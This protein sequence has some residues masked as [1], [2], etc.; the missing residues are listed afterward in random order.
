M[1]RGQ[2]FTSIVICSLLEPDLLPF[3]SGWPPSAPTASPSGLPQMPRQKLAPQAGMLGRR[4]REPERVWVEEC[5][6]IQ[7]EVPAGARVTL[8]K[9]EVLV[10]DARMELMFL[11][12]QFTLLHRKD[13]SSTSVYRK[14][15]GSSLHRFRARGSAR[16]GAPARAPWRPREPRPAPPPS[17]CSANYTKAW[18]PAVPVP[19]HWRDLVF[20]TVRTARH[21]AFVSDSHL[22]R[23][24]LI[25]T[26]EK[27]FVQL[28]SPP[29]ERRLCPDG[30]PPR[31][32]SR[33]ASS[34]AGCGETSAGKESHWAAV[35]HDPAK[36]KTE[37][38]V[39]L[40][41]CLPP[42]RKQGQSASAYGGVTRRRRRGA[43]PTAAELSPAKHQTRGGDYRGQDWI[44]RLHDKPCP[45]LT[46][47]THLPTLDSKH[48][49][50]SSVEV[51]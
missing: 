19:A 9:T 32:A 15:L 43:L 22:S 50:R 47:S 17:H 38:K 12:A 42:K 16:D 46:V 23:H 14:C 4:S 49:A 29:S 41:R 48:P 8:G 27:P 34:A 30:H 3:L 6:L 40:S 1:G 25:H 28:A 35:V 5:G 37:L 33:A 45:S 21:T 2:T 51:R 13:L 24:A 7:K 44:K 18:K 10:G 11:M 39:K 20:A 26:T 31:A 36:K